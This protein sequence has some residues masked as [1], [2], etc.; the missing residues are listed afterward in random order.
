MYTKIQ[1]GV[2][3]MS[4][5]CSNTQDRSKLAQAVGVSQIGEGGAMIEKRAQVVVVSEVWSDGKEMLEVYR[6]RQIVVVWR[7][8]PTHAELGIHKKACL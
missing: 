7:L 6:Y 5:V 4:E 1:C 2:E 3:V 8:E